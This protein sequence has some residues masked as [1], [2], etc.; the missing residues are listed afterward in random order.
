MVNR[1]IGEPKLTDVTQDLITPISAGLVDIMVSIGAKNVSYEPP[2]P[3]TTWEGVVDF[4]QAHSLGKQ[5]VQ[6]AWY[7]DRTTIRHES[8]KADEYYQIHGVEAW[9][10]MWRKDFRSTYKIINERMELLMLSLEVNKDLLLRDDLGEEA[11]QINGTVVFGP[12]GEYH[13]F[14]CHVTMALWARV[15]EPNGRVWSGPLIF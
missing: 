15:Q 14:S 9:G 4:L 2:P 7:V 6:E 8:L 13:M 5:K 1:R 12:Y 3:L 11:V 10:Y